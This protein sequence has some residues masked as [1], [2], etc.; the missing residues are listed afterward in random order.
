MQ[1]FGISRKTMIQLELLRGLSTDRSPFEPSKGVNHQGA[2][3]SIN[4]I[5]HKKERLTYVA[6]NNKGSLT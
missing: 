4:H 5:N 3:G 1:Q 6:N 2:T